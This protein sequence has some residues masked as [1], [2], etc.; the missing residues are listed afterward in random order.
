MNLRI[1]FGNLEEEFPAA[2]QLLSFARVP[3]VRILTCLNSFF[4]TLAM[5]VVIWGAMPC[6]PM[7]PITADRLDG[8]E[9]MRRVNARSRGQGSQMHL[10]MTLLDAKRGSFHKSI[11]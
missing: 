3:S 8:K 4:L 9:I 1:D 6:Q 5:G 7:P 2:A 11:L 10:E